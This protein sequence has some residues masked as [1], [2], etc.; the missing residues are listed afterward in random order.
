MDIGVIA[1][2]END[3]EVLAAFTSKLINPRRYAFKPLY[4]HGCGK[5]RRKCAAWATNLVRR[6]CKAL[7]VLHDL[8]DRNEQTLRQEL[9]SELGGSGC[10]NQVILIPIYEIEAWLLSDPIAI[11]I[12]FRMKM[13]PK[14]PGNPEHICHPKEHLRNIVWKN[15]KKRYLNTIHNEKIAQAARIHLVEICSSFRQ[16]PEFLRSIFR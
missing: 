6:G 15:C 14:T 16:Y 2:E 5:L 12:A 8:D 9:A 3:F 13:I 1:E 7:I 4:G 10:S 11:K